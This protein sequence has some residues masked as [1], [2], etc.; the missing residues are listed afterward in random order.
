MKLMI[1]QSMR[2]DWA[3]SIVGDGEP[4]V[5]GYR[6]SVEA[7]QSLAMAL[8]TQPL[9]WR[10]RTG[11]RSFEGDHPGVSDGMTTDVWIAF[12]HIPPGK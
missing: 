5:I 2:N 12:L 6:N 11:Q 3:L 10:P 4:T 7:V 9:C 8:F 1:Y